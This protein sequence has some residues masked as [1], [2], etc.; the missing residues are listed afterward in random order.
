[1]KKIISLLIIMLFTVACTKHP[2]DG[3]QYLI[4]EGEIPGLEGSEIVSTYILDGKNVIGYETIQSLPFE[5]TKA[6]QEGMSVEEV[7]AG[8][9]EVYREWADGQ[10]TYDISADDSNFIHNLKIDDLSLATQDELAA[11]GLSINVG[12][13]IDAELSREGNE[14]NGLQC[15]YE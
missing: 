15:R 5:L 13:T 14:E 6:Y 9:H 3:M 10:L 1:M 7:I 8:T 2:T 11:I 4:C 12:D